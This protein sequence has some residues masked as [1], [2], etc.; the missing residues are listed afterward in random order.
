MADDEIVVEKDNDGNIKVYLGDRCV[1]V[2]CG[3]EAE[4]EDEVGSVVIGGPV[5]DIQ[6]VSTV[7]ALGDLDK[8]DWKQEGAGLKTTRTADGRRLARRRMD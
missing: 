6:R 8:L 2:S 7:D 5:I 3:E 1:T 4:E